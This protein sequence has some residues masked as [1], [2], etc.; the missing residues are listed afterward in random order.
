MKY[1]AIEEITDR[2]QADR[3]LTHMKG[4]YESRPGDGQGELGYDA[5]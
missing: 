5:G 1:L 2:E 4:V 3:V